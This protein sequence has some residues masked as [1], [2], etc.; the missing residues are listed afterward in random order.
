LTAADKE[1]TSL[2]PD[3]DRANAEVPRSNPLTC[4]K[5]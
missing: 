1:K 4:F 2:T 3:F 5:L